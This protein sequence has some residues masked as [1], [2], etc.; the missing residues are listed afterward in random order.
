M[1]PPVA[2]GSRLL[3]AA[4]PSQ[5]S[6][7]EPRVPACARAAPARRNLGF[8]AATSASSPGQDGAPARN[9]SV[10]GSEN[11]SGGAT[12]QLYRP[13]YPF[14]RKIAVFINARIR[15][16]HSH[17][18]DRYSS[19]S[20]PMPASEHVAQLRDAGV[21]L[22]GN[23]TEP[24]AIWHRSAPKR[25]LA[26]VSALAPDEEVTALRIKARSQWLSSRALAVFSV[27]TLINPICRRNLSIPGLCRI[28]SPTCARPF[29]LS[30]PWSVRLSSA[31]RRCILRTLPCDSS[32]PP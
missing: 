26:L 20:S 28:A 16:R 7:S 30:L 31:A 5:L 32:L 1:R 8:R 24:C 21:S 15:R 4:S 17:H 2:C 22:S 10:S 29:E 25:R 19:S 3:V 13:A 12:Q 14:L 27:A 6:R 11:D 9:I 18:Q 23:L